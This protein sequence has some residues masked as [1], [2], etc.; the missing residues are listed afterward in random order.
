MITLK[1][2]Q[3]HSCPQGSYPNHSDGSYTP[4]PL[5]YAQAVKRT[6]GPTLI[7]TPHVPEPPHPPHD[8][9]GDIQQMLSLLCSHLI[10]Q[11]PQ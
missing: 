2:G 11:V 10:G 7:T 3:N 1:Q 9:L 4:D 8:E 6:A 5:S